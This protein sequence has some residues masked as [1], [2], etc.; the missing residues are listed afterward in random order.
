MR[1]FV[2]AFA[3]R[4][5][6]QQRTGFDVPTAI[7]DLRWVFA[8]APADLRGCQLAMGLYDAGGDFFG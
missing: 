6:Q 5:L 8:D 7:E 3:E 2:G 4:I 1:T